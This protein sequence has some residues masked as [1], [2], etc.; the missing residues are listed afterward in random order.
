ML[1][2]ALVVLGGIGAAVWY[3]SFWEPRSHVPAAV[4]YWYRQQ[5]EPGQ[6]QPGFVLVGVARDPE[7]PQVLVH[8]VEVPDA[9][10]GDLVMMGAGER[11]ELVARIA[12]PGRD[13]P[14]WAKLTRRHDVEIELSSAKG[15]FAAVSC[16]EQLF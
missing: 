8:R 15:K 3:V 10:A 5:F 2:V 14:I 6:I 4:A 11:G 1:A 9:S 7:R 16:R 13:H 12:C